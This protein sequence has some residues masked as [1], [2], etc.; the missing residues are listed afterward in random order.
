MNKKVGVLHSLSWFGMAMAACIL[1]L[2]FD[3]SAQPGFRMQQSGKGFE[4]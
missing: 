4:G 2:P 1:F 3:S